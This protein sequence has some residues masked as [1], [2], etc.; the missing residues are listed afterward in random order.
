MPSSESAAAA[1]SMAAVTAAAMA[2][3]G[4]PVTSSFKFLTYVSHF[5]W[6]SVALRS[7]SCNRNA[8]SVCNAAG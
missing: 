4:F 7:E 2:V 1:S 5:S 3:G 6:P 8:L